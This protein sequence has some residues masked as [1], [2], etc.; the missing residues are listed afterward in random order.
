MQK[1][2]VYELTNPQ[3]SIWYTEQFYKGSSV[4]NICGTSNINEE[5]DF[6]LLRKAMIIFMNQNDI[7]KFKFLFQDD[8]VKQ[9]K[10]DEINDNIPIYEIKNYDELD[11]MRQSIVSKP[12][13]IFN[14]FAYN[15]Y[16]FKMPNNHGAF[17]INIHHILADAWTLGFLSRE[18]IRIYS[19]LKSNEYDFNEEPIYSY[20]QYI[21]SEEKYLNSERFKKDKAYWE[22]E[23]N[24]VP[25]IAAIP[26]C[27]DN[28]NMENS[29]VGNRLACEINE[30][31]II[32]IKQY[33]KDNNI[34]LYN[35]FMSV[36]SL[37]ISEIT[38]L[39]EFVIGTPI[40]NRTNFKEKHAA[41]MFIT[42]QPLKINLKDINTFKELTEYILS[43]TSSMFRHQKYP[44]QYLLETLRHTNK[45]VPNLYNVL[46]SYQITN[47]INSEENMNYSTEWTFNGSCANN[48]EIHI[49][50]IN[51]T[52]KLTI[53][54]D[55]K[56]S[57]Y[58]KSDLEDLHSRIIYIIEQITSHNNIS[59]QD[60]EIV[61]ETEKKELI[62][63]FND[64]KI[65]YNQD[66]P[67]IKYFEE[68]VQNK[69]DSIALVFGKVPMTY[70]ELNEK[71]NSLA[72]LL[73]E[74]GVT[75]NTIL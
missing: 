26:S 46:L 8:N 24:I 55:Y 10:S 75:N 73:R 25:E 30:N 12:F 59:L 15:F 51:D 48:M 74:N 45:K 20:T 4:H 19:K 5:L 11:K 35:F 43:K 37:Y 56:T 1:L 39:E 64:T 31:L 53:D 72:H 27:K 7:F 61:T 29:F 23:F 22:E 9:Y 66:T 58:D 54:Y 41:G 40:L 71:S 38:N 50:D 14:S 2:E 28:I 57:L 65:D 17:I 6:E 47:T 13:D 69:P 67:I 33:C 68:Q 44:Y 18:V 34:S 16:I 3:K 70:K 42:T 52:G 49:S 36:Y 21:N 32:A 60:I 63:T 62:E